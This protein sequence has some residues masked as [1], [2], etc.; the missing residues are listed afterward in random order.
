MP[1]G[2]NGLCIYSRII[3]EFSPMPKNAH[4]AELDPATSEIQTQTGQRIRAI[5]RIA[6]MKQ[7][8]IAELC[9]ADQSQWSRWE[10]GDRLAE[11]L[12]MIRFA[13]RAQASLDLIYRGL[14]AGA[15]PL[16]VRLLRIEV[17]ELVAPEHT[18]QDKDMDL[19]VYR[20]SIG[21]KA[22]E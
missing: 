12:P 11:L 22:E 7:G 19:A 3:G 5:R 8:P 14:P 9:G 16:L 15:N 21:L 18:E 6:G 10:R 1:Q 2:Q 4:S 17:P 20:S 13:R